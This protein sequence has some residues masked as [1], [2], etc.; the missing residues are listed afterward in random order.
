MLENKPRIG[1]VREFA[2]KILKQNYS[3]LNESDLPINV[4][5]IVTNLGFEVHRLDSMDNEHSAIIIRED[6]LIGLNSKH[7]IHRLRFSLCHELAHF[8]IDH[9]PEEDCTIEEIKLYNQEADEFAS[10]L[11]VPLE[12][13]KATIKSRNTDELS[14]LFLVSRHVIIIKFQTSRLFSFLK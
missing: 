6:K 2:R 14:I 4:E 8:L 12:L 7:H 9:P 13:F 10:E 11:L 3:Q 5:K 1:Y